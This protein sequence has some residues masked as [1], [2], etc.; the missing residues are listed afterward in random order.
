MRWRLNTVAIIAA[1]LLTHCAYDFDSI[2]VDGQVCDPASLIAPRVGE[3][4][5]Q[6]VDACQLLLGTCLGTSSTT[7]CKFVITG[8][9]VDAEPECTTAFGSQRRDQPCSDTMECSSGLTCVRPSAGVN[10]LCRDLCTTLADCTPTTASG[11]T[12]TCD[13]S[14]S[15]ATI[16]DVVLYACA[17]VS[18]AYETP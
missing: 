2:C 6:H 9:S 8:D 1:M 18:T 12:M 5:I 13:R 10:G 7:A 14:R 16:G 3:P 15:V 17:P 4:D 11:Q